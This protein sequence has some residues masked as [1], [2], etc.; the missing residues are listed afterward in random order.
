ME[1]IRDWHCDFP[2]G[3]IK[4]YEIGIVISLEGKIKQYETGIVI[5]LGG[6]IKH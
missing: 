3:E 2:R 1:V 6:K 5:S 4:Q